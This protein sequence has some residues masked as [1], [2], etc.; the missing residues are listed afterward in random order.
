MNKLNTKGYTLIEILL[1][2]AVF[3]VILLSA[4]GL[5]YAVTQSLIK[6]TVIQ[7][8]EQQGILI[9][10]QISK[11]IQSAESINLPAP[12][13]PSDTLQITTG[14][15]SNDSIIYETFDEDLVVNY[16]GE[17]PIALHNQKVSINNLEFVN[18]ATDE[19]PSSIQYS[20]T[21]SY[22]SESTSTEYS[23]EQKF[24]GAGSLRK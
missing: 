14:S 9:V 7:E 6:T 1:Y 21:L 10:D 4:V 23:Y 13:N 17:S 20:F 11:S 18:L 24:F 3:P 5:F 2:I 15:P 22:N 19:S 12:L 8:V 16:N